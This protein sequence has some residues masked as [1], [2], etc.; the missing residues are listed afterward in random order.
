MV[1]EA[2]GELK[3]R[4]AFL[5]TYGPLAEEIPLLKATLNEIIAG[6]GR[7]LADMLDLTD[8]ANNLTGAAT[9]SN[10]PSSI[11]SSHPSNQPSISSSP[12]HMQSPTS[13]PSFS[14][15]PSY[16]PT[17][18]LAPT[19]TTEPSSPPSLVPTEP[20][21]SDL[22]T[23]SELLNEIRTAF[24]AA[25]QPKLEALNATPPVPDSVIFAL[26]RSEDLICAGNDRAISIDI[27][28]TNTSKL[29]ITLCSFLS[30]K[31]EGRFDADGLLDEYSDAND[32]LG[33]GS[34]DLNVNGDYEVFAALSFGAR[35]TVSRNDNGLSATVSFDPITA[36]IYVDG[37]LQSDISF[38]LI[39]AGGD[40]DVL[41]EGRAEFM[42]CPNE[43]C[44]TLYPERGLEQ[45]NS[46]PSFFYS[47]E[48]G[49]NISAGVG[50]SAF[51]SVPGL[52]IAEEF[53]FEVA[54]DNIFDDVAPVVDYPKFDA[55]LDSFKFTPQR[56][57]DM[58][59]LLDGKDL[60]WPI[61]SSNVFRSL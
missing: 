24:Q 32:V 16:V 47:A 45:V 35:L 52:E 6:E 60:M 22:I 30:Y 25:T 27:D 2:A 48:I 49:Y 42:W 59:R 20:R 57:V 37:S 39:Q 34:L 26:N 46:A 8:W 55:L 53:T 51:G 54:D 7:T 21:S 3:D 28:F 43:D 50:L 11:P 1:R 36:E 4:T 58:L 41:L 13:S 17:I 61:A 29:D 40:A 18:S 5:A 10:E 15:A 12:T 19:A 33:L 23:L 31:L 9:F 56:A 14:A 38:G 44:D